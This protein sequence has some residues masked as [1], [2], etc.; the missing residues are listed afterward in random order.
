VKEIFGQTPLYC[1]SHS[2]ASPDIVANL[3][4]IPTSAL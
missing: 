3:L 2:L 4:D 1:L